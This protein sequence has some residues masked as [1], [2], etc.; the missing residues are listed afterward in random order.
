VGGHD[1]RAGSRDGFRADK[2]LSDPGQALPPECRDILPA[3]RLD[4]DI[5]GFGDQRGAQAGLE[6]LY[7]GLP[8]AEMGEGLVALR[9]FASM[10]PL[11]N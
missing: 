6:M 1:Q 7:P 4:A 9:T 2:V 3:D 8:L 10:N 5:A 11:R